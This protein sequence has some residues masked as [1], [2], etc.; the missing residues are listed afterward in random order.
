LQDK[1]KYDKAQRRRSGGNSCQ[2]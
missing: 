2:D 1:R